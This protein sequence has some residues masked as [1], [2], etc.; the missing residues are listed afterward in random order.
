MPSVARRSHII[1][2]ALLLG[3]AIGL[4]QAA[5]P[6]PAAAPAMTVT[7]VYIVEVPPAEDHAFNEGV[8]AWDKCLRDHGFKRA[9]YVYDSETGDVTRYLFL[10]VY[11]S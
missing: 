1:G 8:K 2:F 3:A 11:T 6:A 10:N 7:R 5:A 4:A 9:S